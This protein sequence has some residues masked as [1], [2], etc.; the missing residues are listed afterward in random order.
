MTPQLR[1]SLSAYAADTL[2]TDA[3]VALWREQGGGL[4]DQLPPAYRR[5]L[6]DMLMRI[7]SSRLFSGDSCSFSRESLLEAFTLWLDKAEAKLT[8]S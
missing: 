3:F 4:C 5:A 2:S 8:S 1:Q 7:E 6:D